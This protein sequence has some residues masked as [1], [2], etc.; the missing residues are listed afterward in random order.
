M[1]LDFTSFD[2]MDKMPEVKHALVIV[3]HFTRY[4]RAYV[5][6]DQKASTVTMCLY[7]GFI[8]I[9][10]ALEKLITDQDKAFTS[11]VVT[12]LC[13]QFGL[14]KTTMMPYHPQENGQIEQALQTLGN[15]IG[16][17]EDEHKKQWPKHLAKF[18]HAYN[19]TRSAIT[20]LSPHFLMFGQRPRLPIDFLFP[21]HEVMGKMKPIDAC[22]AE[23]IGTLRK[24][25]EV[26]R[27]ITQEE[28]TWQK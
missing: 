26:A 13:T 8:L 16:N 20:G 23:L 14:G 17:M 24:A 1:Y 15:M 22:V 11:E 12:E 25:F 5:T 7:K 28:A 19:S 10:G 3:D 18:T 27:G 2:K 6:K 21:S 9:F 4:M